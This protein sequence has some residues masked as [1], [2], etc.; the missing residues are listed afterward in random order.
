VEDNCLEF[1]DYDEEVGFCIRKLSKNERKERGLERL[2]TST[3][4][5]KFS[6]LQNNPVFAELSKR[7]YQYYRYFSQYEHFSENGQGDV[8]VPFGKDNVHF[9]SAM[10]VIEDSVVA[11]MKNLNSRCGVTE[12]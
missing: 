4:E 10:V 7:V 8:L 11:L 9:P 12:S 3:M 5:G 6:I 1:F 2:T